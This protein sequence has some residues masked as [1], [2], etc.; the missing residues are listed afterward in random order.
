MLRHDRG[1]GSTIAGPRRTRRRTDLG[2]AER[3]VG[4]RALWA[5]PAT[6]HGDSRGGGHR[7]VRHKPARRRAPRRGH[8]GRVGEVGRYLP[9]AVRGQQR[10]CPRRHAPHVSL[11]WNRT[12]WPLSK[13]LRSP[14]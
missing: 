3:G 2:P 6:D 5:T 4:S 11:A 10:R 7:A 9:R 1:G 14:P 8:H 12:P 13:D